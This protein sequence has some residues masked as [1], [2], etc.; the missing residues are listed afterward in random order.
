MDYELINWFEG[1][2]NT[3]ESKIFMWTT[4]SYLIIIHTFNN[5]KKIAEYYRHFKIWN[6]RSRID[7]FRQ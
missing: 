3:K 6:E 1:K 2:Y 7:L 4:E 5:T